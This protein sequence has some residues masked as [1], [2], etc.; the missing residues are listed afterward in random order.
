MAKVI[1]DELKFVDPDLKVNLLPTEVPAQIIPDQTARKIV[2][3]V[4]AA[5]NG[6]WAHE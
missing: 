5:P 4:Y 6:V 2:R 3:A 1:Q